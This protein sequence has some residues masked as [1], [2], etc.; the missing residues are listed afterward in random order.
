MQEGN[1]ENQEPYKRDKMER[2]R[3]RTWFAGPC[4]LLQAG[5][6]WRR[7]PGHGFE[8]PHR[9]LL[10]SIAWCELRLCSLLPLEEVS[11][12]LHLHSTSAFANPSLTLQELCGPA[13]AHA[14][15]GC[16]VTPQELSPRALRGLPNE[17]PLSSWS[18]EDVYH[19]TVQVPCET[20]WSC[21]RNDST[22]FHS[23]V[24]FAGKLF[25]A[26]ITTCH[27]MCGPLQRCRMLIV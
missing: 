18:V 12:Y 10:L 15:Q 16:R 8:H 2:E 22:D 11:M 23:D 24:H 4:L 17:K 25:L 7:T 20:R 19:W 6:K 5:I 1:S 27:Y 21:S 3:G 26:S 13:P 14:A 9:L